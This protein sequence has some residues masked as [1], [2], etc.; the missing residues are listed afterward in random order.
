[1]AVSKRNRVLDRVPSVSELRELIRES[2][3]QTT[4]LRGLL[5]VALQKEAHGN[6]AHRTEPQEVAHA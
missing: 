6:G 4:V 1:M 3:R 5:K 2:V